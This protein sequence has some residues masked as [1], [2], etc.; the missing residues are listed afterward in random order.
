MKQQPPETVETIRVAAPT[1]STSPQPNIKKDGLVELVKLDPSIKLDTRYATANN[2]VGKVI[3]KEA[4]AFLQ[5]S[6][7]DSL[8]RIHQTLKDEGYGLVIFDGYRPLSATKLFWEVTPPEKKK[9][10]ANPANGSRHNRGCA[11]DLGLFDLKSGANLDM[12]TDFDDF[13]AKAAIDYAGANDLQKKNRSILRKAMESDGFKVYATE[14]WHYDFQDCP[15]SRILNIEFSDI[16]TKQD[17]TEISK[18]VPPELARLFAQI[19]EQ[20]RQPEFR[21]ND[22]VYVSVSGFVYEL[23]TTKLIQAGAEQ[24]KRCGDIVDVEHTLLNEKMEGQAGGGSLWKL[25][26]RGWR[27]IALDESIGYQYDELL[28]KG[29]SKTVLKC[30]GIVPI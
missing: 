12:P 2:F 6:A 8:V 15:E 10:V 24:P 1:P 16:E 18:T 13:T 25:E 21:F 5:R 14:W 26:K 17:K 11:V 29:V 22:S 20:A 30:L 7:A 9:F 3:Y 19:V 28:K 27:Q 23:A 4:R